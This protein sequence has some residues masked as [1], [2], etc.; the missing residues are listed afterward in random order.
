MARRKNLVGSIVYGV[1]IEQGDRGEERVAV[2]FVVVETDDVLNLVK[3]RNRLDGREC[4]M[5]STDFR[6]RFRDEPD[7]IN[8]IALERVLLASRAK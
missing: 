1:G 6:K 3:V 2:P 5:R 7:A 8:G 4:L